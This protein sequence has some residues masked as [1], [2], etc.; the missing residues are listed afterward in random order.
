MLYLKNVKNNFFLIKLGSFE[1]YS[2]L[3]P[4]YFYGGQNK[5]YVEPF[6]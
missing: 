2:Y 6:K 3:C 1:N 4:A 5:D